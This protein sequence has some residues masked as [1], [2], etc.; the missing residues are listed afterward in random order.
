MEKL[1]LISLLLLTS[2]SADPKEKPQHFMIL[3]SGIK[4][5]KLA[6]KGYGSYDL[7]ECGNSNYSIINATNII[8]HE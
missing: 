5:K 3:G 8:M 1:L 4:C 2:C 7:K 6:Y